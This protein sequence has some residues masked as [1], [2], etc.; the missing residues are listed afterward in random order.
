MNLQ[1][2]VTAFDT[3]EEMVEGYTISAKRVNHTAD[4]DATSPV[5]AGITFENI[6]GSF[7]SDI[8]V[9]HF[10]FQML[11]TSLKIPLALH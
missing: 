5:L 1:S 11:Q 7:P 3:E 9:R 4:P 8:R 2:P 6:N 10:I